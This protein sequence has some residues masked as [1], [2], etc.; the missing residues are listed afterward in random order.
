[1]GGSNL[2]ADIGVDGQELKDSAFNPKGKERESISKRFRPARSDIESYRDLLGITQD[3]QSISPK[4]IKHLQTLSKDPHTIVAIVSGQTRDNLDTAFKECP[5]L[6]M[7]AE[8]GAW[9][10]YPGE[11]KKWIKNEKLPQKEAEMLQWQNIVYDVLETY[12]ERTNGSYIQRKSTALAWHYEN[13]DPH[14]GDMQATEAER[15]LKRIDYNHDHNTGNSIFILAVGN[16]RSDEKMFEAVELVSKEI[17]TEY[18]FTV[19]IGMVPTQA[20]F[21]LTDQNQMLW[22]LNTLCSVPNQGKTR[23]QSISENSMNGP[24]RKVSSMVSGRSQSYSHGLSSMANSVTAPLTILQPDLSRNQSSEST[25]AEEEEEVIP[26]QRLQ[27]VVRSIDSIVPRPIPPTAPTQPVSASQYKLKHY[28]QPI[29]Q[30]EED[31]DDE[32]FIASTAFNGGFFDN[33]A[34]RSHSYTSL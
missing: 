17:N 24:F 31:Q 16:D 5:G 20:R 26:F 29:E 30:R 1:M 2:A 23:E 15:Y 32:Q 34:V 13:A 25:S 19:R 12:T 8:K 7:C 3:L 9:F 6:F 14:Y 28:R 4:I 11:G 21:Y 10:R 18:G 33:V 27:N 22:L